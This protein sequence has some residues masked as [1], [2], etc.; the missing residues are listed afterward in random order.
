MMHLTERLRLMADLVEEGHSVAD[1]GTDHGLLPMY[2]YEN[3][4]SPK[5]IMCDISEPSLNKA[6][7]L[8]AD[9]SD[10]E[11]ILFRAGDGLE[12]LDFKEVDEVIIAGMGGILISEIIGN[13]IE[14]SRSFGKF[15]LQPRNNEALLRHYLTVNGFCIDGSALVREGRRICEVIVAEPGSAADLSYVRKVDDPFWEMPGE[16]IMTDDA[17]VSEY[18]KM[19]IGKC[20]RIL[21]G[22]EAGRKQCEA[23]FAKYKEKI[24]YFQGFI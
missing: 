2:L 18:A 9:F 20:E 17:L 14:K 19:R 3:K 24:N 21:K 12:V 16:Y 23:D 15:I 13:N 22:L 6:R 4:I 1:I 5:V 7:T 8:A 10:S 11:N